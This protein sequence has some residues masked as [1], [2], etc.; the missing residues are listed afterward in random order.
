MRSSE[1]KRG[2]DKSATALPG[3]RVR[4]GEG[5]VGGIDLHLWLALDANLLHPRHQALVD[6]LLELLRRLPDVGHSGALAVEADHMELCTGGYVSLPV[7][8]LPH[9]VVLVG[10]YALPLHDHDDCHRAHLLQAFGCTP[11][12][13]RS[14]P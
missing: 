12:S 10:G 14:S 7:H 8:Q 13:A 4:R 6:E 11:S 9:A 2:S 3:G 5:A 1:L